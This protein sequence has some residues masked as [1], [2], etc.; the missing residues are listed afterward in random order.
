MKIYVCLVILIVNSFRTHSQVDWL[1]LQGSTGNDEGRGI[2]IDSKENIYVVGG[3]KGNVDF[4]P[5]STSDFHQTIPMSATNGFIQKFHP[6]QSLIWIKTFGIGGSISEITDVIIDNDDNIYISGSYV[7]DPDFSTDESGV[8]LL[9]QNSSDGFVA[10][11]NDQ[12]DVVWAKGLIGNSMQKVNGLALDNFDNL[13]LTGQ[14]VSEIDL[15]P[16]AGVAM[17]ITSSGNGFQESNGF[18]AK[19]DTN[20]QYIWGGSYQSFSCEGLKIEADESGNIY[21]IGNF[22]GSLDIDI[23]MTSDIYSRTN[24][25]VFIVKMDSSQNLLWG[26]VIDGVN[27]GSNNY[28]YSLANTCALDNDGNLFVGGGFSGETFFGYGDTSYNF[29]SNNVYQDAFIQ[30]LDVNGNHQWTKV[31]G[32]TSMDYVTDLKTSDDG[33]LYSTG[34]FAS[35]VQFDTDNSSFTVDAKGNDLYI[36]SWDLNGGFHWVQT[37]GGQCDNS[38]SAAIAHDGNQNI[39][40]TGMF[41]GTIE[42]APSQYIFGNGWEDCIVYKIGGQ[43]N[44]SEN[45]LETSSS[46]YPNPVNEILYFKFYN[47][48]NPD[49]VEVIDLTGRI[50]ISEKFNNQLSVK[51]LNNG[52]YIVR[53]FKGQEIYGTKRIN[54]GVHS[55]E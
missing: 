4:N 43:L 23:T 28:Y 16:N 53:L 3:F 34:V 39:Y 22:K 36:M 29:T 38:Y 48:K 19:W 52:T 14:Y 17:Q 8:I 6:D 12:G 20:G 32:G 42:L 47:G 18:V 44:V 5:G 10:K 13:Y 24:K 51:S 26:K 31:F 25:S 50:V 2:V 30:K 40:G 7:G 21:L 15:D 55:N 11:Y 46:V 33:Q 27:S 9:N 45:A 1:F 54:V 41:S 37:I 35:N 49:L